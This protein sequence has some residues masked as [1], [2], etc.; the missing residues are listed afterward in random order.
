MS[1]FSLKWHFMSM[2]RESFCPSE[3]G[4]IPYPIQHC[5]TTSLVSSTCLSVEAKISTQCLFFDNCLQYAWGEACDN[6]EDWVLQ[7]DMLLGAHSKYEIIFHV[8]IW[9]VLYS[10]GGNDTGTLIRMGVGKT[11]NPEGVQPGIQ[12]NGYI[13]IGIA[14]SPLFS[15]SCPK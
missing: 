13:G 10:T 14:S 7:I 9:N 3:Q 15:F 6:N 5:W 2:S 4:C 8:P 11:R 1:L 12:W